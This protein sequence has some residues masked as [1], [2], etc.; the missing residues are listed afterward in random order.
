MMAGMLHYHNQQKREIIYGG[1]VGDGMT[2]IFI[3]LPI[4]RIGYLRVG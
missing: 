4:Q 1:R 3:H 2:T